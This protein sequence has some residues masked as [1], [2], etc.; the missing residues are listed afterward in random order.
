MSSD[1]DPPFSQNIFSAQSFTDVFRTLAVGRNR[2]QSPTYQETK[3]DILSHS[4]EG[5]K[6]SSVNFGILAPMQRGG[7]MSGPS[8]DTP[9]GPEFEACLKSI[10]QG[11]NLSLAIDEAEN[12]SKFIQSFSSD[13]SIALWEA[14]AYLL[15]RDDSL[16]A[17]RSATKLL[18]AVSS[19]RDL[20]QASK[21]IVFDSIALDSPSDVIPARI[22]ALISLSDRG[23]KL[24]F[25]GASVL[26]IVSS[27]LGPFFHHLSALRVRA[28]R[29]GTPSPAELTEDEENFAELLQFAVD[30]ITLQRWPPSSEE[31]EPLLSQLIAICNKAVVT[32][33]LRNSLAVF[34]AVIL[35]ADVPD[36]NFVGL[37]KVLC[38]IHSTIGSLSG[39]SSRAVRNMAKS[40]KQ[41]EMLDTLHS[42]LLDDSSE[43]NV[44]RGA[45]FAFVDLVRAYGQDS[46]PRLSFVQLID[47]LERVA[48]KGDP[49][50]QSDT[51]ELCLNIVDGDYSD[52]TLE[53]DWSHFVNVL[54]ECSRMVIVPSDASDD[55]KTNVLANIVNIASMVEVLWDRLTDVQRKEAG[56]F[57]MEVSQHIEPSQADLLIELIR[58]HKICY[59]ESKEW[60]SCCRNMIASFLR[61][62]T[63]ASD[64]RILALDTLKEAFSDYDSFAA[65]EEQGLIRFMLQDF[66]EEDDLLYLESLVS[67]IVDLAVFTR[68]DT[69]FMLLMDTLSSQMSK[70]LN[71]DYSSDGGFSSQPPSQAESVLELSLA[72][73][74]SVGVVRIFL[75]SLNLSAK[76][77]SLAF[78]ALLY[79]TRSADRHTDSRLTALKLLFR[80]QCDSAGSITVVDPSEDYFLVNV[81][82][83][84][85]DSAPKQSASEEKE[86]PASQ[87]TTKDPPNTISTRI[88]HRNF[89][90][91]TRQVKMTLPV[92]AYSPPQVLPEEPPSE[93]SQFVYAYGT[94]PAADDE[95]AEDEKAD[96]S[97]KAVLK[98]NLWL[99]TII[100][101][102]QR[103]RDWDVYS[104]VLTHLGTQLSNKGFFT[105]ALPQVLF[106][107]SVLCDQVKNETFHE[108]PAY[109]GI[110]KTD[111]AVCIFDCLS[112]LVSYHGHF[113]RSEQDELV[114]TFMQGIIGTW[115]GTTRLCLHALSV[116][117]HEIP[118]SVTRS[119]TGILDKIAKVITMAHMAVHILEFLA[120]VG[121]LPDVYANLREEEIRTVFGICIR[122]LQTSR[123]Q[124]VANAR[125]SMSSSSTSSTRSSQ[126]SAASTAPPNSSVQDST[127]RYVYALTHHV[128]IFWFLSLELHDRAKHVNW[129]TSRLIFKDDNGKE[130]VEEQSQVFIDFMQ[131]VAFS[132]LGDTIPFGTFPPNP[133]DGPVSKKSWIVGMSIVTVETAGLSGLSQITKRQASGTTYAMYQQRTAPVLPHQVLRTSDDDHLRPDSMRVAVLPSH[134]MLQLVTTAFPTPMVMQPIPIPE[135]DITRRALGS[136]DRND[137]VDGYKMGILFV[138]KD[139]TTETQ[140]LSNTGGSPAYDNFLSGLG[141]KIPLR[142]ALFN[143]Q[144]LYP[145]IDGE[146]TYAWRDRVT[147]IV[148]HVA[149]MMPTDLERDPMCINKKR[150]IGNDFVNIIFNQSNLPFKFDTIPSQFNFVNIVISPACRVAYDDE[151]SAIEFGTSNTSSSSSSSPNFD[152][153]YYHVKVM[154][155]PGFPELSPAATTKVISGK[156]LPLFIR[157]LALNATVFSQVWNSE[158]GEHISS[159]LNRMREIK[160]LRE[161]TLNSL[162][163]AADSTSSG[164]GTPYSSFRRNQRPHTHNTIHSS[165][166]GPVAQ[167]DSSS[168]WNAAAGDNALPVLDFSR[169]TK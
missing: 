123:E 103:E 118:R 102:L 12:A 1:D 131:R 48:A 122:S 22:L 63:K 52:V 78:E 71:R 40:R 13:Q 47:S 87:G 25:V 74:C 128:M 82:G 21:R 132:D 92:W 31:I 134:V 80:L 164:E 151:N 156:N 6:D 43:R 112:M 90:F 73:V 27:C 76:K 4:T 109:T 167:T 147:E 10:A 7:F 34:D 66:S 72:N 29:T 26:P 17:R 24:E 135:N 93:A 144:G 133:E 137:I 153:L 57:L 165:E 143:T 148:Y 69:T 116:C 28:R 20:S 62:R 130:I 168:E 110:K 68:H 104:Y 23:R 166:R 50:I 64:I 85:V 96:V 58:S 41:T 88:S 65:F 124:R 169:W 46:I 125:N 98:V 163:Q 60:V 117:C 75:R 33:D 54:I 77:A 94:P 100:S 55:I 140:I 158:D 53:N 15:H 2:S 106:L 155:K 49:R 79:I 114:R 107:R 142:G 97:E 56:R 152:N 81:L 129:I 126:S 83:R 16:P 61:S 162:S 19:R 149:T 145:D 101:L 136:F 113:A 37:L 120:L 67:F 32:S 35:Y 138:D 150:H 160:R 159:W 154:S 38:Q 42:F 111:V 3:A 91:N 84:A 146:Y 18:R 121:R 141:T 30:L 105:N 161:R 119:L 89:G 39:P 86:Q 8:G 108:P 44:V 5:R 99:E 51:L 9:G 14:G 45:I 95:K 127:S 157:F 139:Q 70:D 59:P 11:Q 36:E 115:Q